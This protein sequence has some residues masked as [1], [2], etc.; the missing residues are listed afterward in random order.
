VRGRV[1]HGG[2]EHNPI[3]L[4]GWHKAVPNTAVES[5]RISGDVD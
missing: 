2:F 3:D 1:Y 5:F 4:K